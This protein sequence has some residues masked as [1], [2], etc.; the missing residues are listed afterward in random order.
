VAHA[1]WFSI[2]N[3]WVTFDNERSIADK[4]S[5]VRNNRLGGWIIWEIE[6]DYLPTHNPKHPLLTA[7]KNAMAADVAP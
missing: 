2:S 6:Q 4:V 7:I 5:Y 3:G 1:P